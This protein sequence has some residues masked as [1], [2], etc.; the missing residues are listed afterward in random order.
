MQKMNEIEKVR[1]ELILLIKAKYPIIQIESFEE[2]RIISL[3]KSVADDTGRE[4]YCWSI[5]KGLIN[6]E[7]NT[8]G[9][10]GDPVSVLTHIEESQSSQGAIYVLKDYH[11]FI[12]DPVITRSLRDLHSSL[13]G[14][15]KTIIISTPTGIIPTELEKSI[16]ILDLPYPSKQEFSESLAGAMEELKYRSEYD[17]KVDEIYPFLSEQCKT[18]ADK[19]PE[20]GLGLTFDEYENVIY[21][22]I[23]KH[24]FDLSTIT[25]EKKQI[26]R[27]S[28]VLEYFEVSDGMGDIGGL[29]ELKTWVRKAGKRFTPEAEAYGLEK[30]KGILLTGPPGTGKSLSAKAIAHTLEQPLLRLDMAGLSSK[31]YGETGNNVKQALKLADAVAPDVLWIDEIEKMF[32]TGQNGEGH[33]ETMR[34]MGSILTHFEESTSAVFRVATC[35]SPFNLKPE[36]MQRFEKVFFV[37]LPSEK[38]RAEIFSIHLA[39]AGRDPKNFDI[40]KLSVESDGFVG[41]EIRTIVK[42]ALAN[43]FDEG[44]EL[45]TQHLLKEIS[46]ITP[47]SEQK[48]DEIDR[49]R[50]WA[51]ANAIPASKQEPGKTSGTR[52]AEV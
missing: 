30:P 48:K 22:C 31:Y 24:S 26:I 38:E 7:K 42:E 21:K 5:T 3:L 1:E 39:K 47:M 4:L 27:K 36:I 35:N 16:T 13:K 37:D 46:T 9:F 20:A 52:K 29:D 2:D 6:R 44:Q 19:I 10:Q 50:K 28:G 32:S 34:A 40:G 33:E 25:A 51:K 43:A 8:K 49:L 45:N 18:L 14:E 17:D 11:K 23:S 12:E 15:M 41:R